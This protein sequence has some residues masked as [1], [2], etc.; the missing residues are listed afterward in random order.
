MDSDSSLTNDLWAFS[1]SL[2]EKYSIEDAFHGLEKK[3]PLNRNVIIFCC[4]LAEHEYET[5]TASLIKQ[6]INRIQRWHED[7]VGELASLQNMVPKS[8]RR[9]DLKSIY[10][11]ISDDA[12]RAEKIEQSLLVK[13]LY[14]MKQIEC[15]S[16]QKINNALANVFK[17]ID[18]VGAVIHKTDLEKVYRI[19]KI[20]FEDNDS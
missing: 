2:I 15:D 4:W 18:T 3:Y 13:Y 6:I 10:T 11:M 1:K 7:I 9:S 5:L 16:S 8:L 20:C 12:L 19:V 17:Y 14:G